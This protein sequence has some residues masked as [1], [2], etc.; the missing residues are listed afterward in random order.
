VPFPFVNLSVQSRCKLFAKILQTRYT[1]RRSRGDGAALVIVAA[2][3]F[4]APGE[5]VWRD[6]MQ[7]YFRQRIEVLTARLDNLRASLERAR[8]SVT[9]LEN[10]SVPAG[11]TALAR[12]AQLSAAR[13]MAATLADRERHLLIAIQSLQAELADQQLTEHE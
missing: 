13:A 5:N 9:R 7:T 2:A 10:E 8:Q 3:L 12:A 4:V 1:R 11:A 6:S